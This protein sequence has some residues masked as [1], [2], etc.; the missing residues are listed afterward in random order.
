M[1]NVKGSSKS[2]TVVTLA[3]PSILNTEDVHASTSVYRC[4]NYLNN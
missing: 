2:F 1:S 4:L 3:E